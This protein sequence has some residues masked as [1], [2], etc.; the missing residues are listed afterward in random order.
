ML[1]TYSER[2]LNC[3]ACGINH[4]IWEVIP[5]WRTLNGSLADALHRLFLWIF[6]LLLTALRS[7]LAIKNRFSTP[8]FNEKQKMIR[9]NAA[10][11]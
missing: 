6:W 4:L 8:F 5:L 9:L 3:S 10:L 11:N 7:T 2:K 1:T